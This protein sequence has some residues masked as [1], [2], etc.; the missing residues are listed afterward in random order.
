MGALHEGHVS[1]V[2]VALAENDHVVVSIFINPTQFGPTE[3]F[4]RYP[5]TLEK[6]K[7]LLSQFQ[8]VSIYAPTVEEMYPFGLE[9]HTHLT[10]PHLSN[11]L[12]GKSR[13]GHFD[14]VLTVV[15]R[16]F[17][18]IK[19]TRAYFGEKDFQQLC[20][21]RHMAKDLHLPIDIVGCPIF[22]EPDGLAA[23]SR[24]AYLSSEARA[25]APALYQALK[26]RKPILP[27]EFKLDYFEIVDPVSLQSKNVPEVGDR[28]MIAAFLGGVRLIDNLEFS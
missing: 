17:N 7:A 9:K 6:D 27:A 21:I 10:L 22:R 26:Q 14:G 16:L 24:N 23:S 5:R 2:K 1:L 28:V 18:R 11:V 19:P 25:L 8:N 13:P 20:L 4:D 15:L 3:D 12:C